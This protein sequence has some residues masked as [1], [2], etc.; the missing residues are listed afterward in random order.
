[1]SE[2][3]L[4]EEIVRSEI[5]EYRE[6]W[7]NDESWW[8][9]SSNRFNGMDGFDCEVYLDEDTAERMA[10]VYRCFKDAHGVTSADYNKHH[11]S[12]KI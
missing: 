9:G 4:T 10:V 2:I 11:L 1:M 5:E 3:E 12:F 6:E 7:E 8:Y